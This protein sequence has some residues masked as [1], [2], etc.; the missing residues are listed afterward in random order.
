MLSQTVW[1]CRHRGC[2]GVLGHIV[3]A[4]PACPCIPWPLLD[5]EYWTRE[6]FGLTQYSCSYTFMLP[7]LKSTKGQNQLQISERSRQMCCPLEEILPLPHL[8][9]VE[10][11]YLPMHTLDGVQGTQR[12]IIHSFPN[13]VTYISQ[14][15]S[16][17]T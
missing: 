11:L 1:G 15:K 8:S 3:Y 12:N 14:G 5:R 2:K 10:G 4:V 6:T 9:L 13:L 16:V 7:S 17:P